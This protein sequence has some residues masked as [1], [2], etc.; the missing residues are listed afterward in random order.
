[1]YDL[2]YISPVHYMIGRE[3]KIPSS[4]NNL[5]FHLAAISYIL[6]TT[7]MQWLKV[8]I[9]CREGECL[10]CAITEGGWRGNDRLARL[11][12]VQ[13]PPSSAFLCFSPNPHIPSAT[14]C[15]LLEVIFC[16]PRKRLFPIVVVVGSVVVRS[17]VVGFIVV[18]WC[19]TDF[20]TD[21]WTV[22]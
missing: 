5:Y 21:G 4:A 11:Q 16:R 10:L 20:V 15:S 9:I 2:L 8:I 12:M 18:G 17:A 6:A 22:K 7:A 19:S 14:P 1:M 3:K 13:S